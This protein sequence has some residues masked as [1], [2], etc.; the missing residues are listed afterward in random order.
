MTFILK[1]FQMSFK[2]YSGMFYFSANFDKKVINF[3]IEFTLNH[4]FLKIFKS[5]SLKKDFLRLLK[6]QSESRL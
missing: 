2:S 3:I 6:D 5:E 4:H 1:K